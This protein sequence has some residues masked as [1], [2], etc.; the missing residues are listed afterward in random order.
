MSEPTKAKAVQEAGANSRPAGIK[1]WQARSFIFAIIAVGL[2]AF[3]SASLNTHI[4][5]KQRF[6]AYL[7]CALVSSGLKVH[8]PGITGTMSVNFL[9]VL[10]SIAD[11][12]LGESLVISTL[13]I[14]LQYVWQARSRFRLLQFS[15]NLSSIAIAV[16]ASYEV[17]HSEFVRSLQLEHGVLIALSAS[18]YFVMNTLPIA[19][20]VSLTEKKQI[21]TVWS[22]CYFWSFPYYLVGAGLVLC[23][24]WASTRVGWQTALLILPL[25]YTIYRSY[26]LYLDRLESEKQHAEQ[27]AGLHLRT[28]EALALAI[29]AKD[30][31]TNEHLQ[32][33]QVY[34]YEIGKDLGLDDRELDALQAAALLHDIGKLA[35]PEHIISKP[36]RLTPEEFEKMKI[37][38]LVGAEILER[39][40]FPYPVSP[41]VAAHHEKWDGTGYPNGLSGD[42]I[43]IG[44]R[45]LS[46]VDCLDALASDRQYRLALPLDEAMALVSKQ[47]GTAFDPQV[48]EVL[49]RRYRELEQVARSKSS[50]TLKLSVDVKLAPDAAPAAGYAETNELPRQNAERKPS[51]F[52]SSIAAARHEVQMLFELSQ[53]LG[54]SL[55]VSDTLSVVAQ[56]LASLVPHDSLV[57]YLKREGTLQAEY[58]NGQD[59]DLFADLAIPTGQ[60]LSGWVAETGKPILNGNPSVEPGYLN[61]DNK[62]S[63]LRSALAI[64]L[65]GM[66]GIIG[67]VSL[68]HR[69]REAFTRDHLRILLAIS[70]KLGL[71]IENSLRFQQAEDGATTDFL[72]SLPNGRSLFEHL[73]SEIERCRKGSLPLSVLVCDL[74]GFKQVNDLYGHLEG[75][76]I[77]RK[78]AVTLRRTCREADYVARMGGDEFVI[79]V[80]GADVELGREMLERFK[81]AIANSAVEE[82]GEPT[83]TLSAGLALMSEE[84]GTAEELL[85]EADREMY[86][87]KRLHKQR[88]KLKPVLSHKVSASTMIQ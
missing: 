45:I 26:R 86:K 62:F 35:V 4:G 88:I 27:M 6:I 34:A 46:A 13:G 31:I 40:Q 68:Y 52:L 15:F 43:P 3:M 75:N 65:E 7:I 39:V 83:Y 53:N 16:L 80:P 23:I 84:L 78:V 25:V 66:N 49:N 72:T 60:G 77:L 12:S 1:S 9:F 42:S 30:H 82:F 59:S 18:I 54:A 71:S 5:S 79:V 63:T 74:D 51:N 44:A 2:V 48:I 64:P 70:S 28:I 29:E 22:T 85:A 87:A 32:R 24:Q 81:D 47:S 8:L 58:V 41:I 20:A 57:V 50:D 36:G 33:V 37:H 10:L 61:D 21:R 56:R 11:L 76:R 19:I 55:S 69:N 67:V 38:P 73:E 14:V 17:L